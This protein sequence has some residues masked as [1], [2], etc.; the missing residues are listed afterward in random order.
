MIYNNLCSRD[1]N[2]P[3]SALSPLLPVLDLSTDSQ[4]LI[5]PQPFVNFSLLS[6]IFRLHAGPQPAVLKHVGLTFFSF[7]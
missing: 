3:F 1:G 5:P 7:H 4:K 6:H 2:T